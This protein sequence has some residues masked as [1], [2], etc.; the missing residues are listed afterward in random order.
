MKTVVITGATKGLGLHSAA[1][2]AGAGWHVVLGQRDP[3][4]GEAA[5]RHIRRRT[6]QASVELL[7]I[8]L[9]DLRSVAEAAG[10]LRRTGQR[11]PLHAV[12]GNGAIQIIDGVR[13]SA[14]GYELTFATNHLGHHLLVTSLLDDLADGSRIAVVSS[15]THWP[16]ISMGFPAPQWTTP[17]ELADPNA[18]DPSPTAGRSRYA[19]SKLANLY[20]TYELA[21]RLQG[22]PITVNAYDPGLMP[23]TGLSRNYPRLMQI[24]YR[25]AT[26]LIAAV[27]PNARSSRASAKRLAALITD[28]RYTNV[29][30]AYLEAGKIAES[31]PES[32]DA[33]KAQ[34]LWEQSEQLIS[35]ALARR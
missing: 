2:L 18:A 26:P 16:A 22:R 9:A 10:R 17:R 30:G 5:L 1:R 19:S 13:R 11:P 12:I 31:S 3:G 28:A 32:H 27:V 4:R 34:E 29:S 20:F 14:D 33:A 15:G 25:A 21:R 35:E 24:G 6:P 7:D 23:D 8:D